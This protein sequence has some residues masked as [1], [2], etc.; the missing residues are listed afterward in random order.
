MI[1]ENSHVQG[2]DV[3][4]WMCRENLQLKKIKITLMHLHLNES[5][6]N[7]TYQK[8]MLICNKTKLT[9]KRVLIFNE[10]TVI[11]Y[12][13]LYNAA[14]KPSKQWQWQ[15]LPEALVL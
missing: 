3:S 7:I 12:R 6:L 13:E 8:L 4:A 14:A 5:Y 10:M 9:E 11:F 15:K 2:K 1:K